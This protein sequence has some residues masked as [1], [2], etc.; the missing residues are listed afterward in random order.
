MD[1]I[2][3]LIE[4]YLSLSTTSK[5]YTAPR[6]SENDIDKQYRE[7]MKTYAKTETQLESLLD[8]GGNKLM[9][10]LKKLLLKKDYDIV[11]LK[12]EVKGTIDEYMKSIDQILQNFQSD[13]ENLKHSITSLES[14]LTNKKEYITQLRKDYE[15]LKPVYEKEATKLQ[16]RNGF[17]LE[18]DIKF[19]K[20]QEAYIKLKNELAINVQE[21]KHVMATYHLTRM[22]YM[23]NEIMAMI[24]DAHQS[25]LSAMAERLDALIGTTKIKDVMSKYLQGIKLMNRLFEIEKSIVD[26]NSLSLKSLANYYQSMKNNNILAEKLIN[27]L[28]KD[29]E[30]Y[31][32][33]AN[34][35]EDL[36]DILNETKEIETIELE[37]NPEEIM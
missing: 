9:R 4:K 24:L 7:L 21:F 6:L 25:Y 18:K 8:F 14:T 19:Y 2:D 1:G 29:V 11:K 30:L 36:N 16:Q 3:E 12:Q 10:K 23:T 17:D 37:N 27:E 32:S 15:T 28:K 22:K 35:E 26:Q 20:I 5:K 34:A 33:I 13:Q 31:K